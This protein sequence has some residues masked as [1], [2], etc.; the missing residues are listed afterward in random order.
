MMAGLAGPVAQRMDDT[1]MMPQQQQLQQLHQQP[2]VANSA[3]AEGGDGNVSDSVDSY[4]SDGANNP[5]HNGKAI[6]AMEPESTFALDSFARLVFEDGT[7]HMNSFEVVIGRD[8]AALRQARA[9]KR[10]RDAAQEAQALREG[11]VPDGSN[12]LGD[13]NA[14]SFADPSNNMHVFAGGIHQIPGFGT[15]DDL[16]DFRGPV[17][18]AEQLAGEEDRPQYSQSYYSEKGGFLGPSGPATWQGDAK[19]PSAASDSNSA[20]GA[21]GG[22][23]SASAAAAT[24]G[25]TGAATGGPSGAAS[26]TGEKASGSTGTDQPGPSNSDQKRPETPHGAQTVSDHLIPHREYIS[27]TPDA[28]AVNAIQHMPRPTQSVFVG[29]HCPGDLDQMISNTQA[30]SRVHMKIKFNSKLGVFQAHPIHSNGFFID[31]IHYNAKPVTLRSGDVVQIKDIMFKFFISGTQLGLSGSPEYDKKVNLKPLRK[32]K[33]LKG[34]KEMSFVFED[35]HGDSGD[36]RDTTSN[37]EAKAD[38]DDS[39]NEQPK[40][41]E[42]PDMAG[43]ESLGEN[44]PWASLSGEGSSM[45]T[46]GHAFTQPSQAMMAAANLMG[47]G[48][49]LQ[50][51][52]MLPMPQMPQDMTSADAMLLAGG[53]PLAP[54]PAMPLPATTSVAP[55]AIM[56]GPTSPAGMPPTADH[57]MVQA[58]QVAQAAPP[59]PPAM[60]ANNNVY[61]N[62][63]MEMQMTGMENEAPETMMHNTQGAPAPKKPAQDS[64]EFQLMISKSMEIMQ[65]YVKKPTE[66]VA[67][68]KRGPGRPPKLGLFSVREMR[69]IDRKSVV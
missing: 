62:P 61:N 32:P 8:M 2:Q 55:S 67:E 29:I 6:G 42:E 60:Q 44:L 4:E 68:K 20:S 36:A 7:F 28:A 64:P 33:K 45:N 54:A 34:N 17:G 27:H 56:G 51:M 65:R 22:G 11:F 50:N 31:D 13:F 23:A 18:R 16:G 46:N 52:N 1:P 10:A 3:G 41:R 12:G 48:S 69:Q 66:D 49:T 35:R 14:S 26:G 57:S 5:N 43:S 59:A 9:I 47:A 19:A 39:D 37:D 40:K 58:A 30:I 53:V 25:S 21:N 38:G 63:S 15:F 24:A